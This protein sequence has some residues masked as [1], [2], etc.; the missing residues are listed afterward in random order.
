MN[1][2]IVSGSPRKGSTTFRLAVFLQKALQQ[3]TSYSVNILDVREWNFP[4][5]QEQVY[6]SVENTPEHYKPL[7]KRMFDAHAFIIV[8]PEYNGS[9]TPS[10]KNLFDHFPKQFHKAFGIVT[11]STGSMGGMRASQ[12]LQL[13]IGALFGIPSPYMLITPQ[14]DKKFDAA[15]NLV[16]ESFYNS[17]HTF[18]TEFLWLAD[19]ICSVKP[20]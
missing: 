17:V 12:Q 11:A 2:E 20:N 13:L 1:I 7:A 6:S 15:G 18:I 4:T 8:T 16:D 3:K 14:V 10:M 5:L 9:Y 19:R